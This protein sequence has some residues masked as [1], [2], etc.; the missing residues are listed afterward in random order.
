MREGVRMKG[1]GGVTTPPATV[2]GGRTVLQAE[3]SHAP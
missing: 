1:L 2:R 3:P